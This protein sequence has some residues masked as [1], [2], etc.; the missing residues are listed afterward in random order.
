MLMILLLVIMFTG[1]GLMAMR[2]TQGEVRAAGS[3]FD[4]I[5]AEALAISPCTFLATD[6]RANYDYPIAAA[7]LSPYPTYK[8][9]FAL[10]P[11]G[12]PVAFSPALDGQ[13]Y[14]AGGLPHP[15]L[16]GTS[17]LA[18]TPLLSAANA[19]IDI[20]YGAPE[21]APAMAGYSHSNDEGTTYAFYYFT[22]TSRASFGGQGISSTDRG[23]AAARCRLWVGPLSAL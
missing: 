7:G 17:P 13:N 15:Q 22:F 19:N 20:K 12:G 2:H 6:L 9:Q 18:D 23:R 16:N 1:L 10:N 11:D 14:A 3:Y 5:Q 4:V 21:T 8:E